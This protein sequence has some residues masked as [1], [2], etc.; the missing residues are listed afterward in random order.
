M[1]LSV[2][3]TFKGLRYSLVSNIFSNKTFSN[4]EDVGKLK[5]SNEDTSSKSDRF[6]ISRLVVL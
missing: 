1:V 6:G 3:L 4:S 5:F 2:A